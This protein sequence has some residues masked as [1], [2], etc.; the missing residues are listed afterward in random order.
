MSCPGQVHFTCIG[1]EAKRRLDRCFSQRQARRRAI[2]AIEVKVVMSPGQLAIHLEKGWVMRNSLVKEIG[3]VQQIFFVASV[4]TIAC[5]NRGQKKI[6]GTAI[7]VERGEVN[8][9]RELDGQF[10]GRG[11]LD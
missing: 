2:K 6:F 7:E 5:N 11:Y 4:V 10:L 3:S 9:W 8:G 1:T